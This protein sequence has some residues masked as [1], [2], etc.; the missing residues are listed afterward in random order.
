MDMGKLL[1]VNARTVFATPTRVNQKIIK[2]Q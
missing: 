2:Y 1:T